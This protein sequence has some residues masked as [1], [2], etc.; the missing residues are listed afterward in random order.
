MQL[1]EMHGTGTVNVNVVES[2]K[3]LGICGMCCTLL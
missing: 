1:S 3:N 2:P